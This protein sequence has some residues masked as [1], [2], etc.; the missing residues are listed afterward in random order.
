[1]K[2]LERIKS[3]LPLGYLYLIVLG[4][5]K[6]SILCYPLGINILNYSSLTD[7]LI[8]PISDLTSSSIFVAI[9]I[10][11]FIM[12]LIAQIIL[13]KYSH[14]SWVKKML[15]TYGFNNGPT[16]R[17]IQR[18]V[19]TFFIAGMAIEL[20]AFFVTT[21]IKSGNRLSKEILTSDYE[22]NYKIDFKSGEFKDVYV[23][24][25]NSSYYFYSIKGNKNIMIMP[26][27][28]INS[29]ELINNKRLN[30]EKENN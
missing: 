25:L 2:Y 4:L 17:E 11:I 3:L 1:M 13:V 27:G 19:F 18:I 12:C 23:F 15:E 9:L 5:L 16:K 7:I 10:P 21:G 29:I 20:L 14:K 6:E 26:V 22:Y 28:S 24:H 8:I 30:D